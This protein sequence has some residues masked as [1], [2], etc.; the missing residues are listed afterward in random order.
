MQTDIQNYIKLCRVKKNISSDK[1][2]AEKIGETAQN[3]WLKKRN[4]NYTIS[5]LEKIATALDAELQIKFIDKE[6]GNPI[7]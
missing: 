5:Y 2:L 6:T 7:I 1:E 4:G 3:Y